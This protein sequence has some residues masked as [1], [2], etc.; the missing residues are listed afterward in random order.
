MPNA[1][2]VARLAALLSEKRIGIVAHFYMDAEVQG[3]LTAAKARL[4][5]RAAPRGGWQSVGRGPHA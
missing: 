2:A 1:G 4:P 5:R 3:V